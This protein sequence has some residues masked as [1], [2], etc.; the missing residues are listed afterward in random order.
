MRK[1]IILVP[2]ILAAC[3]GKFDND[4]YRRYVD[5]AVATQSPRTACLSMAQAGDQTLFNLLAHAEY[6]E[7]WLSEKS[8]DTDMHVIAVQ[9][10]D[11]IKRFADMAAKAKPSQAYCEAKIKNINDTARI[12]MSAEGKK[13]R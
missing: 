1:Y 4:V 2:L 7:V 13:D 3:T 10:Y 8:D 9:V 11:E 6:A 12:A 5:I